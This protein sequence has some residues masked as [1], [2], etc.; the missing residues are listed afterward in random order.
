M[1][2]TAGPIFRTAVLVLAMV[3]VPGSMQ[4]FRA[5]ELKVVEDLDTATLNP[6]NPHLVYIVDP[7]LATDIFIVDG[8]EADMVGM[9][10]AGHLP[11]MVM[12]V[13]K[14]RFDVVETYWSRGSRGQRI[15][16]VTAYD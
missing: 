2:M 16:V 1:C 3:S 7:K 8:D 14:N 15:D 10:S 12:S 9:I 6:D 4:G 13:D 5:A 11:N